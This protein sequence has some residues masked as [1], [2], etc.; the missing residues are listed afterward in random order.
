MEEG[1]RILLTYLGV[2]TGISMYLGA[3][4]AKYIEIDGFEH[5]IL[6]NIGPTLWEGLSY[7]EI[8]ATELPKSLENRLAGW[9]SN[10]EVHKMQ[11]PQRYIKSA[12]YALAIEEVD[13]I[14]VTGLVSLVSKKLKLRYL[15]TR[16]KEL[17]AKESLNL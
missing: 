4:V 16:M 9:K 8:M 13:K 7:E 2:G 1:A 11:N 15:N 12:F 6:V 17:E 10:G 3:D 14:S 5:A